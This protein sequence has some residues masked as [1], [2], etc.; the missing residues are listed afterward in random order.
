MAS[1][2]DTQTYV[3]DSETSSPTNT[4]LAQRRFRRVHP[5]Y[6]YFIHGGD[7]IKIGYSRDPEERLSTLQTSTADHLQIIGSIVGDKSKERSL[8]EQFGHLKIR[9]EWF[10]PEADLI[11]FICR[12]TGQPVPEFQPDPESPP[13]SP[14]AR[15]LISVVLS[16]RN[17]IGAETSRG[18]VL[19]NLAE[20]AAWG[21]D[22]DPRPWATH[23]MQT[24]KGM[25]EWQTQLLAAAQ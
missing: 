23:P 13:L 18:T 16:H 22:P 14:E 6:V 1:D 20:M 3:N 19:S 8:H 21:D 15:A 9:N 10:R 25:M 17:Q 12:V 4:G 5:G 24:V 7:R 2:I 11:D